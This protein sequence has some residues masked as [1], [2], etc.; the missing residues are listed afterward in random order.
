MTLMR[1]VIAGP[2]CCGGGTISYS[3][4][5]MRYRILNSF[6]NGSKW[7]SLARSRI[8]CSSTRFSSLMTWLSSAAS[9]TASRSIDA[10]LAPASDWNLL[11]AA[12][13]CTTSVTDSVLE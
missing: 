10:P 2:R 9:S 8:A 13:S 11:S 5:S 4:P 12:S 7:M 3:T 1:L 6:S